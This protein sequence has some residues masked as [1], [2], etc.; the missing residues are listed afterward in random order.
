M[1]DYD[2]VFETRLS[3]PQSASVDGQSSTNDSLPDTI[4]GIKFAEERTSLA[5]SNANGGA[6]SSW[7]RR[8]PARVVPP[9]AV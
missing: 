4:E 5:G 8:R 3:E 7:N 6:V 2:D 1:P 9:G